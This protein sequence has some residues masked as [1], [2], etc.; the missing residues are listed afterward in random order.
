[1][2]ML[3]F[4]KLWEREKKESLLSLPKSIYVNLRLLPFK[5]AIRLP[6]KVRYNTILR[7][8]SGK[9]IISG[10]V[11]RGMFLVGFGG[12]TA[13]DE[14]YERTSIQV[15]GILE[16]NGVCSHWTRKSYLYR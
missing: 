7:S 3:T 11:K 9:C 4:L 8:L 12:V 2:N 10:E 14:K 1:M 13:F 15:K 16:L 6:I 5:Q